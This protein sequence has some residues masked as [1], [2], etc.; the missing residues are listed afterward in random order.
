[1]AR[2]SAGHFVARNIVIAASSHVGDAAGSL[3][4]RIKRA[5]NNIQRIHHVFAYSA[6]AIEN[7]NQPERESVVTSL[8][9]PLD[10]KVWLAAQTKRNISS[11]TAEIIRTL[12]TRMEAERQEKATPR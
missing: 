4:P 10:V 3:L 5:I 8:R 9:L 6:G 1:M 7:M 2:R 11:Q 12:R